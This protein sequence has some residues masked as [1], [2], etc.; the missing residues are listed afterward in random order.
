MEAIVEF[1][2]SFIESEGIV[3]WVV[4]ALAAAAVTVFGLGVT[5]LLQNISDPIR[6]RMGGVQV[7]DATAYAKRAQAGEF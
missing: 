4:I 5:F 7:A 3:R 6:R 2:S 1:L